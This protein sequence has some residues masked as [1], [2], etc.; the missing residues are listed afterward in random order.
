MAHQKLPTVLESGEDASSVYSNDQCETAPLLGHS[1]YPQPEN[2][3]VDIGQPQKPRPFDWCSCIGCVASFVAVVLV[4]TA[5]TIPVVYVELSR[6]QAQE[7][8]LGWHPKQTMKV[9]DLDPVM[10]TGFL[11]S[12]E[13]DYT[14]Y[15][16]SGFLFDQCP[17]LVPERFRFEARNKPVSNTEAYIV[18]FYLR[19]G[20]QVNVTFCTIFSFQY[21]MYVLK[22][23]ENYE[24]W[25]SFAELNYVQQWKSSELCAI[26]SAYIQHE[27]DVNEDDFYFF[28]LILDYFSVLEIATAFANFTVLSMQYNTSAL[29]PKQH[30]MVNTTSREC[31]IYVPTGIANGDC[32]V[33]AV[34]SSN[35]SKSYHYN[36]VY[37]THVR[38]LNVW[39]VVVISVLGVGLVVVVMSVLI[40]SC[41]RLCRRRLASR[42]KTDNGL[43]I[44]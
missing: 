34:D 41:V 44:Q 28:L 37:I 30:C 26:N 17:P 12:Y 39:L 6:T 40:I 23:E 32:A 11:L 10:F 42:R 8:V 15:V 20:S 2:G 25:L 31:A 21:Y 5:V 22:G 43:P 13:S 4:A 33:I 29:V 36:D 16:A 35:A 9:D 14:E 19:G 3:Q 18:H 24:K 38:T 1:S 7:A 27:F